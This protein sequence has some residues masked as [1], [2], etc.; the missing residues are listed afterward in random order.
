MSSM[1]VML[2]HDVDHTI[3]SVLLCGAHNAYTRIFL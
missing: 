2:S 1:I 3:F